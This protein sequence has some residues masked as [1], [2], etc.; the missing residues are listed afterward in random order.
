MSKVRLYD[1]TLELL[2][3]AKGGQKLFSKW[4]MST[5]F[6][7]ENRAK[8]RLKLNNLENSS[9]LFANLQVVDPQ[10]LPLLSDKQLDSLLK[11]RTNPRVKSAVKKLA[12][13]TGK[14]VP[15]ISLD[16]DRLKSETTRVL[17]SY[18]KLILEPRK[19]FERFNNEK[20]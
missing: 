16:K 8:S 15:T 12:K 10:V 4:A 13:L 14:E 6:E 2:R 17:S 18:K 3:K 7:Y 19:M 1:K 5:R 9:L 11:D 20:S